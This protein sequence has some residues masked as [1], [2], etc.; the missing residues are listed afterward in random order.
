M[1]RKGESSPESAEQIALFDLAA[2]A[3]EAAET[4]GADVAD[5]VVGADATEEKSAAAEAT[6]ASE[7]EDAAT[8]PE[9]VA[10]TPATEESEATNSATPAAAVLPAASGDADGHAIIVTAAGSYTPSGEKL[11]GPV[12]SVEK[13][14]K[15]IRWATL[16]PLGAP[17]QVW[18]VGIDACEMFGWIIDPGDEDDVDDMEVLRTRAAEELTAVLQ[19]TLTPMLT[20]GWELR[21][22]PGHVVHLSRT[23]GTFTSMVDIFIEPYVWTYWNKDFGWN[24][25]VG[26]MGILGSPTAGTYL[27]DDDLSAARELGR[28]LSWCARY[29][30]VLP[31]P[32]PARTGAAVLDKI[33]RE[34]TRSGKGIAVTTG[35]PIPPLNGEPRGDLEPEVG[36]TRVCDSEDLTGA[37]QLVSIDQRAAY[38]ASAGMLEFGYGKPRHLTG[39]SAVSAAASGAKGAPFGLWRITLPAGNMLSLPAKLPLPHP[40]MLADQPVQ[41]W[42]TSV[43]LDALQAS[44]VDGGI[45]AELDDLDIVEAWVY[46][47][48]G[49]ALD[50]WAK[51]LREGRKVA[52][53]TGDVAM[54]RFLGACYKGYIGRMVNPDMWTAKQMQHHHQ[55]LWRASIIAHCRWRGRR[56]AMRIARETGRW[57]VRTVTDS[58][59]YL[60]ADGKDV[61]D[62][63][64]ALGKM[65]VEKRTVL[66]EALIE[67]FTSA[68]DTHEM[69]LAIK[70]AFTPGEEGE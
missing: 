43:S 22:D 44:V 1:N 36:W 58:W 47:E 61:A 16:T 9:P 37:A 60:L 33:K 14:D 25:R 34:R 11:T 6:A 35:G 40:H 38:L 7:N 8:T 23:T 24:N 64:D 46:P 63:S 21:G 17:A 62:D 12:D 49:R 27:P 68:D 29:L 59:V 56:V 42:V 19:A 26:D 51:I 54:K 67:A 20:A 70:G 4:A 69:N 5:A 66:T 18:V 57:P 41:T 10:A 30:G 15:L 2:T 28:R 52:V 31:G 39:E 32:T 50:K 65:S 48:Q 55:P 45:G 13:L 53:E 3:E